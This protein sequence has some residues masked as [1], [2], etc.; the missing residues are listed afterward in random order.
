[1]L[2]PDVNILVG[3]FRRDTPRGQQLAAWLENALDGAEK[4]GLA[5]TVWS[6][7]V[8]VA[9]NPKVFADPSPI[10][11]TLE[12]LAVIFAPGGAIPIH[13][14]SDHRTIFDRLCR[15]TNVRGDRVPDAYLAAL[16]I[17]SGST[18]V[19]MDRGFA[20]Y[21]GLRWHQPVAL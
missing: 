10:I 7:F 17:E 3:A 16:A 20:L 11:D 12:F 8:R 1:M 21:E 14:G 2:I 13:P 5:E 9:T 15:Q 18:F 6:G 19:T 4:V